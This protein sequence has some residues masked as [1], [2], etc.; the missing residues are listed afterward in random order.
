MHQPRQHRAVNGSDGVIDAQCLEIGDQIHGHLGSEV[1]FPQVPSVRKVDCEMH[2]GQ[3]LAGDLGCLDG[4]CMRHG[5]C[6]DP[7]AGG[8]VHHDRTVEAHRVGQ[9][10]GA[11]HNRVCLRPWSARG[12]HRHDTGV[13]KRFERCSGA[14]GE[15][16]VA[17]DQRA[18]DVERRQLGQRRWLVPRGVSRCSRHVQNGRGRV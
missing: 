8:D 17:G 16:A 7:L 2:F 1:V 10:A 14:V 4:F 3:Q 13:S 12:E 5:A 6:C 11:P 18:V 15:Y 9:A